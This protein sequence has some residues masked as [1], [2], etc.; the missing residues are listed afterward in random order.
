MSNLDSCVLYQIYSNSGACR[1]YF[2]PWSTMGGFR[3]LT[4]LAY[5]VVIAHSLP[6]MRTLRIEKPLL[7]SLITGACSADIL[8]GSVP[9][10][11]AMHTSVASQSST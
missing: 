11:L 4:A 5:V 1:W 3:Q 10:P 2:N 9:K 8:N 6:R 7:C